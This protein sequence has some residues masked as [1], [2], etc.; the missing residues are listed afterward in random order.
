MAVKTW[1]YSQVYLA[2]PC[3]VLPLW[4]VGAAPGPLSQCV[5]RDFR[6]CGPV[7][8]FLAALWRFTDRGIQPVYPG[9]KTCIAGI[10]FF[11]EGSNLKSPWT[12]TSV[13]RCVRVIFGHRFGRQR[14]WREPGKA[15]SVSPACRW[16]ALGNSALRTFRETHSEKLEMLSFTY[17]FRLE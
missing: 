2:C 15:S 10:I 8:R 13:L 5:L 11:W 14:R 4:R 17:H 6:G 3:Q 16:G 12:F 9:L 1:P 7:R